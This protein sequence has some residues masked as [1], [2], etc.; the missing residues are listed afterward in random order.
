[1]QHGN[2]HLGCTP[3]LDI[4]GPHRVTYNLYQ[5]TTHHHTCVPHPLVEAPTPTRSPRALQVLTLLVEAPRAS[6]WTPSTIQGYLAHKT[7]PNPPG[8]P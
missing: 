5:Y 8:P 2:A 6:R 4:G 3:Q 7:T 1:M